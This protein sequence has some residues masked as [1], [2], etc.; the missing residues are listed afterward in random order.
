MRKLELDQYFFPIEMIRD[1]EADGKYDNPRNS[2]LLRARK[3]MESLRSGTDVFVPVHDRNEHKLVNQTVRLATELRSARVVVV[4][5]LYTL[6]PCLRDL[7]DVA[8]YVDASPLDRG[9]GRVWRDI[10]VRAR[11]EEDVVA[12]LLGRE[13]YHQMFVE[14]TQMV[15]DYIVRRAHTLGNLAVVNREKLKEC[16]QQACR[17]VGVDDKKEDGLFMAEIPA[18]TGKTQGAEAAKTEF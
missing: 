18:G 3:N 7:G 1:R 8:I 4:E 5:G 16:F 14:P 9:K 17:T 2:D 12:M 13:V 15:A 11:S 10:N 6:G